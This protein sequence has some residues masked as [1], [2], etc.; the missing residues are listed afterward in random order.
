MGLTTG[1][2]LSIRSLWLRVEH[3]GRVRLRATVSWWL[4]ES[5]LALRKDIVDAAL[6]KLRE[7]GSATI[8]GV[9]LPENE[10]PA[11]GLVKTPIDF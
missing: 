2:F 11:L 7:A 3:L 5:S 9:E 10:A 4:S 1:K 8:P 6:R